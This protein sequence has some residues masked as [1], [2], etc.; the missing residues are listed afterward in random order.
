MGALYNPIHSPHR[1]LARVEWRK[2]SSDY[3]EACACRCC[4]HVVGEKRCEA[5]TSHKSPPQLSRTR[6]GKTR[7]TIKDRARGRRGAMRWCGCVY[8]CWYQECPSRIFVR[9]TPWV[10]KR[11]RIPLLPPTPNARLYCEHHHHHHQQQ[12][13]P[14]PPRSGVSR[15]EL[16]HNHPRIWGHRTRTF[17]R[18]IEFS[19]RQKISEKSDEKSLT[20]V[21]KWIK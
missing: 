7:G 4:C 6:G 13:L 11:L 21:R 19:G 10:K 16:S 3:M 5:T 1:L 8:K 20:Q 18:H 14:P 17:S 15:H 9:V 2:L 12:K